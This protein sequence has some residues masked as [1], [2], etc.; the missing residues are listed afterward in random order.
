MVNSTSLM[1]ALS[2]NHRHRTLALLVLALISVSPIACPVLTARWRVRAHVGSTPVVRPTPSTPPL[3][4]HKP[5]EQEIT[6]GKTH[7][8]PMGLNAGQYSRV[9]IECWGI[10][11]SFVI[12]DSRGHN[13]AEFSCYPGGVIPKSVIA[14][15]SAEYRLEVSVR[16]EGSIN[17][18]YRI[19]LVDLRRA[20]S[21][22]RES[23]LG[24]NAFAQAE[25]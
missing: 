14:D 12:Y 15:V 24:E 8:Y 6:P 23:I 20:T 19:E 11:V 13:R 16:D 25:Q 4:L 5:I 22:D 10:E 3:E 2:G 7:S 18:R 21:R 9:L 17:G 1:R